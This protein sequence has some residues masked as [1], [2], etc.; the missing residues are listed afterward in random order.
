MD[1]GTQAALPM[2]AGVVIFRLHSGGLRVVLPLRRLGGARQASPCM[3]VEI[4]IVLILLLL[5]VV[6]FAAEKLQPDVITLL[7][8]CC[9]VGSRVLTPTEAF[10]GFSN[11]ALVILGSV[12]VLGGAL[13]K[14]GWLEWIAAHILR[15]SGTSEKKL[16][17][18]VMAVSGAVSAFMNNTTVAAML[19]APV[20]GLARRAGISASRLLMP[21]AFAVILG[22]TCTL[23]GT[24]TNLAVSGYIAHAG[25]EPLRMFELAP[26]GLAALGTAILFILVF[27]RRLLPD[28]GQ[29]AFAGGE[30]M[31]AYLAEVKVQ[32]GSPL[33]GERAL[34][35]ELLLVGFRLV[36]IK[37]QGTGVILPDESTVIQHGD[38]LAVEGPVE[39]LRRILKI[40]GLTFRGA[41]APE[42]METDDDADAVPLAEALVLPGSEIAGQTLVGI[43][44]RNRYGLAVLAVNRGGSPVFEDL[45]SLTLREGD[46]LLVHGNPRRLA[47]IERPT[48]R[49]QAL[50]RRGTTAAATGLAVAPTRRGLFA[51]VIFALSVVAGLTG[52]LPLPGAFLAGALLVILCGCISIE[53]ARAFIDWRLLILIGGMTAFGTAMEKTGGA[54]LLAS[55]VVAGL[56][57]LGTAAVLGGFFVLTVLMTQPMSNAAAALV[58]L[59]VA[60]Q[61]ATALEADPR[62]FAIAVMLAAS[63]SII[64]PMEPACLLVYG[65][66]RYRFLDFVRV[67]GLLTV[68]V[69]G[70]VLCIIPLVWKL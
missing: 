27:G 62:T 15:I 14:T 45:E 43:D 59:P 2:N 5:A 28:T 34:G 38:L 18:T 46:V 37:R 13:Q 21:L 64:T 26:V 1:A 17:L 48:S 41:I 44:F 54:T 22:G 60:M 52:V 49:L 40:E 23:I 67:G 20:T 56:S 66:G 24:S 58:V 6:L 12:F 30:Q 4:A 29:E 63:V 3:T 69:G 35:W 19:V 55:Y 47:A 68:A 42:E 33:C 11:E 53:E 16:T 10:A 57:P 65:P 8:L 36:Q 32:E 51:A 7:L 25:L 70:V 50:G 31:R 61:A 9:L 39:D